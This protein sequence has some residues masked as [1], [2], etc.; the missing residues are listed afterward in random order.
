[1]DWMLGTGLGWDYALW[2]QHDMI[3]VD[4]EWYDLGR[5]EYWYIDV[6]RYDV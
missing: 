3:D 5:K 2:K 6:V 1:V 4:D